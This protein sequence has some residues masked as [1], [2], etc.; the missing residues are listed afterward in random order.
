MARTFIGIGSNLGDRA[1]HI[2]AAIA[3]ICELPE[4]ELVRLSS[5]VETDPV[6]VPDQGR[7]LNAAAELSTRLEPL[8]L[9]DQ[10]QDIEIGLGRTRTERWGPRTIDLDILLYDDKVIETRRLRVP[11]PLMCE[12]EFVLEPLA[13]IAAHA[14]HPETGRT[15]AQMLDALRRR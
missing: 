5:L 15:A 11:H 8:E 4:T 3:R 7:F 2:A 14:V 1:A 6:G 10:L 12:R 9:L 13:E